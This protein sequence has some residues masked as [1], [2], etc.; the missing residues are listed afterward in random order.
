MADSSLWTSLMDA[1]RPR[2]DMADQ[3]AALPQQQ[4]PVPES[5][6]DNIKRRAAFMQTQQQMHKDALQADTQGLVPDLGPMGFNKS[7]GQMMLGAA[8]PG[9]LSDTYHEL[10]SAM[11][12]R[13]YKNIALTLG[14][15]PLLGM[16][17]FGGKSGRTPSS[18]YKNLTKQESIAALEKFI[19]HMDKAEKFA[20]QTASRFS[21]ATPT[22]DME[23]LARVIHNTEKPELLWGRIQQ[24]IQ[25]DIKDQ[26]RK[27]AGEGV[28]RNTVESLDAP[29]APVL[30]EKPV[31]EGLSMGTILT[32]K[33]NWNKFNLQDRAQASYF[34]GHVLNSIEQMSTQPTRTL[35]SMVQQVAKETSTDMLNEYN[36]FMLEKN[37]KFVPLKASFATRNKIESMLKGYFEENKAPSRLYESTVHDVNATGALELSPKAALQVEKYAIPYKAPIIFKSAAKKLITGQ[38]AKLTDDEFYALLDNTTHRVAKKV[39]DFQTTQAKTKASARK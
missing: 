32:N 12:E 25:S 13:D 34:K 5:F 9:I 37:A 29:N 6:M 39:D 28:V 4:P 26:Q 17:A 22:Y 18:T 8:T 19:P 23:G 35:Q 38:Q 24:F 31:S 16:A 36:T 7:L 1:L 27:V 11:N 15:L 30:A 14:G 20:E 3:L 2:Q 21:N 10:T 33:D